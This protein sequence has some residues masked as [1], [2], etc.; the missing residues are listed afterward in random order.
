MSRGRS[1]EGAGTAPPESGGPIVEV[2]PVQ[3]WVYVGLEGRVP[4]DVL[5]GH[6]RE[7]QLR[8]VEPSATIYSIVVTAKHNGLNQR[9]Y[10]EWAL[11]EMPNDARLAEAGRNDRYLHVIGRHT[12]GMQARP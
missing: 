3:I 4:H 11:T 5:P 8:G 7:V 10:L 12:R 1:A 6:G 2:L 9:A